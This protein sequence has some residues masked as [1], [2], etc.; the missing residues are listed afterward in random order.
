MNLAEW[1]AASERARPDAPALLAGTRICADYALFAQRAAS[2]AHGLRA[3]YGVQPGD[4]V[5]LFMA[6]RCEYLECMYGIWWAGAVAVPVN[7]KLHGREA[8][9]IFDN[10]DV[11]LVLVA[12]DTQASLNEVAAGSSPQAP[13]L[14]V[15]RPTYRQLR[16]GEIT[17]SPAMREANDLAWLFYTSGTTGRPKGVMLSH[18]NLMAMSLCYLADVDTV[19]SE[20]AAL[21]AAPMSHGAG[22]YNFIHVRM[23][24]RHVV[25]ASGHFDADEVLTLA[26]DLRNVSMFAAPTMVRRLV[27]A[28]RQRGE[29]GEGL[30]TIVYGG[31]PMYRADICDALSVMGQRFV[32]IYGQ[33][34]SPMT[35]T[36]LARAWHADDGDPRYLARLA[37]VGTAHSAV[38]VRITNAQGD[39]LPTG[40]IGEIEVK[41]ATVMLGY[42]R[43]PNATA[44]T[45]KDGWLRTG[46]VGR[47]DADGF[48]TLSDRSK[49][50]IIS[51]GSNIYPRE[52]EEAL[53]TH[54][55]VAEIA[56]VGVPNPEWGEIVIACL[57][58]KEGMGADDGDFDAHCLSSIA[59]FKRPKRYVRLQELP[60]NNYG[61]VLKTALRELVTAR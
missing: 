51:G 11:R 16:Q 19:T 31:G 37:S 4:R 32:Q 39:P 21:Y 17:A 40:E 7:A 1:L 14:N 25:P 2:I 10:A 26:K 15:D 52:V 47:L 41:G 30:K 44:E 29:R 55:A 18:G 23:G 56:V 48:L 43:N 5:G 42:W 35:I 13:L 57:V 34:E 50:V 54:P 27:D 8:L 22:L 59:R 6:N 24:A 60:K 20:D 38:Q 9:W 28:A 61:K 36:A 3:Q 45:L 46:D 49:D 12:D 33:G 53:L 58:L